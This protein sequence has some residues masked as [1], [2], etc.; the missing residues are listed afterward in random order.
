MNKSFLSLLASLALVACAPGPDGAPGAAGVNGAPGGQGI[1][2]EAG[3]NG[4]DTPARVGSIVS[5]VGGSVVA[6][7]TAEMHVTGQYTE[8]VEAPEITTAYEGLSL[9]TVVTS[10]VSMVI[11]ITAA[12]DVRGGEA[13]LVM[14]DLQLP[15]TVEVIAAASFVLD[16]GQS[17]P[18]RPGESFSGSIK[19]APGFSINGQNNAVKS[20]DDDDAPSHV[21][22]TSFAVEGFSDVGVIAINAAGIV[23]PSAPVGVM[24]WRVETLDGG[25]TIPIY[26]ALEVADIPAVELALGAAVDANLENGFALYRL[27]GV[28][29][30]LINA[31]TI[32][33]AEIQN[34]DFPVTMSLSLPA[35]EDEPA[36]IWSNA[37]SNLG[38]SSNTIEL[39]VPRTGV[40]FLSVDHGEGTAGA[41]FTFSAGVEQVQMVMA[42]GEDQEVTLTRPG[43]GA[44]FARNIA[45]GQTLHWTIDPSDGSDATPA[46]YIFRNFT[47][48]DGNDIFGQPLFIGGRTVL[49]GFWVNYRGRGVA[50]PEAWGES[51]FI[52]RVVDEDL[53]GGGGYGITFNGGVR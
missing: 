52:W 3:Q 29:G 35:S 22:F 48:D 8:W 34:A 4:I 37:D 2:G 42:T 38:A 5:V 47:D 19:F 46:L 14:G 9:E 26:N 32:L 15:K 12:A 49:D 17:N 33:R 30:V 31:G 18:V 28:G 25:Q 41:E 53:G 24:N 10:P 27:T 1:Q 36:G 7:S 40:Y 23:S 6:G 43:H 50:W 39:L 21:V 11:K 44:W 16:E 20:G 51:V 13:N 45:A